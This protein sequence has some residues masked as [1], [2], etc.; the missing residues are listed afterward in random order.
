M[1]SQNHTSKLPT[2]LEAALFLCK[3]IE[4]S[5]D[6]AD[7]AVRIEKCRLALKVVG[8]GAGWALRVARILAEELG[9]SQ[10]MIDGVSIKVKPRP[11][12]HAVADLAPLHESGVMK[13][14]R[15]IYGKF[16][17]IFGVLKSLRSPVTRRHHGYDMYRAQA[18]SAA[19]AT[20]KE[21]EA[22]FDPKTDP[23]REMMEV[24]CYFE[25]RPEPYSVC[26]LLNGG[27]CYADET[28]QSQKLPTVPSRWW[29]L[30]K[31]HPGGSE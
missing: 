11:D 20:M 21:R 24:L 5:E 18:E 31:R 4:A 22:G 8:P 16:D 26:F 27:W 10:T 9:R 30:C 15:K 23:P 19:L 17:R 6:E 7:E 3:N 2:P 1:I 14:R 13:V 25:G 12:P 29:H 28:G